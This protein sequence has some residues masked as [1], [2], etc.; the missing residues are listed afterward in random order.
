MAMPN[1][2]RGPERVVSFRPR[3]VLQTT[4]LLLGVAVCLWVL[5]VARQTITWILVALF[6]TLA[7][8]PA[9][10]ALERHGLRRRGAATAV[11]FLV[12]ILVVAGVGALLIPPLIDQIGGVAAAPPRHPRRP[13]PRPA[14][15]RLPQRDHP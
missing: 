14:P 9:V 7:L 13:T 1:V 5:Y 8:A 6:L 12:A 2:D 10:S 4:G 3:A 15:P 11:V